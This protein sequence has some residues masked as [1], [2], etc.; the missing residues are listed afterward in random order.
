[1]EAPQLALPRRVLES[2]AGLVSRSFLLYGVYTIGLFLIFMLANF[3]HDVVIQRAVEEANRG[4]LAIGVAGGGF[5][6]WNGY[7]LRE[8]TIGFHDAEVREQPPLLQARRVYVR[9]GFGS[10][11]RGEL[12]AVVLDALL[13]NGNAEAEWT[14]ADGRGRLAIDLANLEIGRYPWL[15]A[16]LEAGGVMG[17]LSG[18]INFEARD[19]RFMDGQGKVDL[20]LSGGSML[21]AKVMGVGVPDLH[22]CSGIAKMLLEGGRLEISGIRLGCDE[23]KLDVGGQVV[24]RDPIEESI[25]NLRIGTQAGPRPAP[26]LELIKQLVPTAVSGTLARPR[27]QGGIGGGRRRR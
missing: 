15:T 12:S 6:W 22:Q 8:V 23:I 11:L 5:A 1:M 2:A 7:E 20:E 9:P 16:L 25:L 17:A 10:L 3:P 27:F 14:M 18:D 21:S 24:I 19:S 26:E 4:P 13:Y